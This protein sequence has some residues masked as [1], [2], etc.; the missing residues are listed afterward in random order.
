MTRART[1]GGEQ[2]REALAATRAFPGVTGP[3]TIN[4]ARDSDKPLSVVQIVNKTARYVDV[5]GPGADVVR[6]EAKSAP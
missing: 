1:L 2:L 6:A 3:I 4:D 5:V